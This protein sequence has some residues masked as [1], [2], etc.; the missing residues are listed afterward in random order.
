M[1]ALNRHLAKNKTKNTYRKWYKSTRWKKIAVILYSKWEIKNRPFV[2]STIYNFFTSF[3]F[4]PSVVHCFPAWGTNE[5]DLIWKIVQNRPTKAKQQMNKK[6]EH[7]KTKMWC[8]KTQQHTARRIHTDI[9]NGNNTQC[10][11]YSRNALVN[12]EILCSAR[13]SSATVTGLCGAGLRDFVVSKIGFWKQ[14]SL[15]FVCALFFF[16][17]AAYV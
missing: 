9:H 6:K 15:F 4:A 11:F 12:W 3:Q 8:S 5:F 13:R 14:F 7:R 2:F 16:Y 1:F 10:D 17:G